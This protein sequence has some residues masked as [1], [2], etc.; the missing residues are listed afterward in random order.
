M[1]QEELIEFLKNNLKIKINVEN[2]WE[3]SEVGVSLYLGEEL[4]SIDYFSI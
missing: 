3:T 1:T 2:C 4:I